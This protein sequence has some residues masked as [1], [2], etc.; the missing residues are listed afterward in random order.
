[1]HRPLL[2]AL[3]ALVVSAGAAYA[4]DPVWTG[5]GSFSAATTSGNTDT[6]NIGIGLE[7][8]H[9]GRVWTQSL[10]ADFDYAENNGVKN[11]NR[12]AIAG[13]VDRAITDRLSGFGRATWQ[14][15]EFSGFEQRWFLGLGLVY[16]VIDAPARSW[17]V[18]GGPGYRVD[19]I[20][21]TNAREE[22]LGFSAGSKF[23]QEFNDVV[24]FTNDT[25]V[26]TSDVSTLITNTA[27]LTFGLFG[28]IQ[29]RVSYDVRH[30]TDPPAGFENTDTAT[31]FSIV[32]K[33][34]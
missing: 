16:D 10:D 1:M 31:R 24:A 13:Q 7:L 17:T 19:E 29:G 14:Q 21:A 15:D 26:V 9:N 8:N 25:N 3:T 33:I 28:D 6:T 30:D 27:A 23:R 5:E 34:D 32:Y 4:Q 11:K 12:T 2:L 18:Q 22:N 20:R